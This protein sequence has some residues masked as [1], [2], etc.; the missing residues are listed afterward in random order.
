[1]VSSLQATLSCTCWAYSS[2]QWHT[3]G[4]LCGTANVC[5][6]SQCT[7]PVTFVLISYSYASANTSAIRRASEIAWVLHCTILCVVHASKGIFNDTWS[8]VI[9]SRGLACYQDT[10]HSTFIFVER[11]I[12]LGWWWEMRSMIKWFVSIQYHIVYSVLKFVKDES[13]VFLYLVVLKISADL[14]SF[15]IG[16]NGLLMYIR[17][18]STIFESFGLNFS[19][20][21]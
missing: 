12:H 3:Q 19:N 21:Y 10:H 17:L 15:Y 14:L 18:W 9:H 5:T 13:C 11:F 8:P 7:Q 20:I 4:A 16:Y 1:M 2:L 6:C